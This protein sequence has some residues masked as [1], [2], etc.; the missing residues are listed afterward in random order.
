MF[1]TIANYHVVYT[2]PALSDRSAM[3]LGNGEVG[4]SLW[5]TGDG[6]LHFYIARTDALTE[7]DRTVKLGMV[8]VRCPAFIRDAGFRQELVLEEGLVRFSSGNNRLEL[9]VDSDSPSV[10]VAGSFEQPS[11][12]QAEYITWRCAENFP[13]GSPARKSGIQ[14]SPDHVEHAGNGIYVYHANGRNCIEYLARAQA[15]GDHLPAIPDRLRGRIFGGVLTMAGA[16]L[17][18][19]CL[20]LEAVSRF[21]TVLV[22]HSAQAGSVE[23]W[24]GELDS[25]RRELPSFGAIK[26]RTAAWWKAYWARSFIFVRGDRKRDPEITAEIREAAEKTGGCNSFPSA[27]TA[28]YVLTKFMTACSARGAFPMFY[29]GQLFNL[30]PGGGRHLD[31]Q[32]FSKT[33]TMPPAG[34]PDL[35]INPDER[36]WTIDHLWQNL[37]LPYYS[38][39]ARG[40]Y[41]ALRVLFRYFRSFWELNRVR[42]KVYYRASGQHN[43]EMTLSCGLQSEGVYGEASLRSSLPDGYALNRYGGAVDISP[44]LELIFLQLDFYAYTGDEAFLQEEVIP[45]ARE[46]FLYIETRFTGRENGKVVLSPLQSLETY[47]DTR[48]PVSVAAGMRAVLGRLLDMPNLSL[49]DRAFFEGLRERSPDLPLVAKDGKTVLDAAKE[50]DGRRRNVET[51][52]L[53]AVYPFRLCGTDRC[54]TALWRDTFAVSVVENDGMHPYVLGTAPGAPSYSGWQTIGCAAAVLGM[55]DLCGEI[56]ENNCA[57]KNPGSRFPAMW[58]PIYDAVPDTDHGANILNQ[59]QLMAFRVEIFGEK[60][61]IYILPAL[62]KHWDVWFKFHAPQDTTVEVLYEAGELKRLIVDPP[63]R[64]ADIVFGGL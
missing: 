12:V 59:L 46:L 9:L 48:D 58:G 56:L 6:T 60:N 23:A 39:L 11:A 25:M 52:Q 14:E 22:T 24:K 64:E 10:A 30:M 13:Y 51:P 8:R 36:S 41:D 7:L 5:M 15:L 19:N 42:A 45:Y 63:E 50:H 20:C 44:G 2:G 18:S 31:I 4:I 49:S 1:D 43:T 28:A 16:R 17:E 40:E 61:K 3:P 38:L 37:R 35:E 21:E 33:F 27:V 32:T 53:Y 57:L 47:F 26:A 54:E 55:G 29:N 62:P 34:D